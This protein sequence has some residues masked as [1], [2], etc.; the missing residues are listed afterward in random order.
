M[1]TQ[2]LTHGRAYLLHGRAYWTARVRWDTYHSDNR[3]Y[4]ADT[5]QTCNSTTLHP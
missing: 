3:Y 4:F 1:H 5:Y 2:A